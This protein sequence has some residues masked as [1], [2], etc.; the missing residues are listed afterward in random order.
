MII[1]G[2]QLGMLEIDFSIRNTGINCDRLPD[3]E[4][5]DSRHDS[6]RKESIRRP[7][8]Q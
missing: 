3:A 4:P 2:Q 6:F 8:I 7:K 1:S 5:I